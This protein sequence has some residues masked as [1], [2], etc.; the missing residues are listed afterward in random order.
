MFVSLETP[1]REKSPVAQARVMMMKDS[2]KPAREVRKENQL[3][4][5]C[6]VYQEEASYWDLRNVWRVFMHRSYRGCAG[7]IN[8]EE[9]PCSPKCLARLLQP[10]RVLRPQFR[11]YNPP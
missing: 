2:T 5:G 6:K 9:Y 10:P 11:V 7:H 8:L 3:T 4:F 1:L